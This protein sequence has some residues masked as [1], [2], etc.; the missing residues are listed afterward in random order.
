MWLT[1]AHAQDQAETNKRVKLLIVN[2]LGK[3]PKNTEKA[4]T[5]RRRNFG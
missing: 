3:D 2:I 5:V 1:F 4:M